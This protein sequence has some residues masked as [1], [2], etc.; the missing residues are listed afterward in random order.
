M[1]GSLKLSELAVGTSGIVRAF[2]RTGPTAIR[3]REMGVLPGTRITLLRI[4]PLGDPLEFKVRGYHLSLRKVDAA[5]V[6]VDALT[7]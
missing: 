3:L 2:A 5:E 7:V 6:L 1:A 4:A